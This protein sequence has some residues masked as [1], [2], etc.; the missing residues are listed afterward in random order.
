MLQII[1]GELWLD[2]NIRMFQ[3]EHELADCPTNSRHA[4]AACAHIGNV[5]VNLMR[6]FL[7]EDGSCQTAPTSTTPDA[8]RPFG[9][10]VP[11]ILLA[12]ADDST[13]AAARL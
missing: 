13:V 4:H 11:M 7:L 12:P 3:N 1:Q 8:E 6:V 10:Y 5:N 2:H 9:V